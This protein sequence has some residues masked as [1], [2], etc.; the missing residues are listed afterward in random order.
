MA[1]VHKDWTIEQWNN[2]L[3]TDESKFEIFWSNR[4]VY[5]RR[6]VSERAAIPSITPASKHEGVSVIMCV[7]GGVVNCKVRDLHQ[8]KGKLNQSGYHSTLQHHTIPSEMWLVRE[9]FVLMQDND[10]KHTCKPC[11]W[12][13]KNIE[14]Q[15]VLQLI[16]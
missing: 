14:E 4:R 6:S 3:W 5:M 1:K 15:H 12:N 13:I 7:Y 16:S 11:Q 9:G 10:P 2:V 8:V